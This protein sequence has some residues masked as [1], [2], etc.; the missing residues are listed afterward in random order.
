MAGHP[1]GVLISKEQYPKSGSEHQEQTRRCVGCRVDQ[2][3][4]G[5]PTG[6]S[7]TKEGRATAQGPRAGWGAGQQGQGPQGAPFNVPPHRGNLGGPDWLQLVR[8]Q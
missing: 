8:A 2:A 5:A 4:P 3:G 6:A 1:L 7:L